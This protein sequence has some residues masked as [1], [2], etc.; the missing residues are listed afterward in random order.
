LAVWHGAGQNNKDKTNMNYF[1][2]CLTKKYACFSGRA[3]RKEYWLFVL[4]NLIASI[5]IGVIAGVLAGATGVGA[6]SYLGPIY[7]LAVL[8]PGFAV[9]FRRLHDIGKSGW[10][11]LIA[12]IPV[13][14]VIVLLVF[15]CLDSQPGDNQYGPNPKGL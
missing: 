9:L 14:G 4:F 12:F 8:I 7:S 13:I 15:C 5:I 11:W 3:R 10:W 6:F 2:D 1:I